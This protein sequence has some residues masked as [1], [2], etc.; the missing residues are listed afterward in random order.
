MPNSPRTKWMQKAPWMATQNRFWRGSF[1]KCF[2]GSRC[3]RVASLAL[4]KSP[5]RIADEGN[6]AMCVDCVPS[7]S[8]T[9]CRP[10]NTLV[11][12]KMLYWII[13]WRVLSNEIHSWRMSKKSFW[14]AIL[15]ENLLKASD[16]SIR[17]ARRS[18]FDTTMNAIF[19]TSVHYSSLFSSALCW[20]HLLELTEQTC[21]NGR[22]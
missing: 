20:A 1:T 2:N 8:A 18:G 21:K 5:P 12:F 19:I 7:I 9:Y 13:I 11:C 14:K 15:A 22:M 4:S 16:E 10:I 3:F 6:P 17:W